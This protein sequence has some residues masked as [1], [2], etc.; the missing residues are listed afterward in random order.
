MASRRK[1]AATLYDEGFAVLERARAE[2]RVEHAASESRVARL[3]HAAELEGQG[4]MKEAEKIIAA[5]RREQE[6]LV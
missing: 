6:R 5:V 4:R 1:S 2:S 3:K